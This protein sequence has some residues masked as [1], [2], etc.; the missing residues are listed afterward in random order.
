MPRALFWGTVTVM[1]LYVGIHWA[2]LTLVPTAELA[3]QIEIG[4][5]VAS[6]VFGTAGGKWMSAMLCVALVS[7]ASAMTWAGPRVTQVMG[8][9]FGF[10]R[11]LAHTN[12]AGIPMR[13]ILL[14][15]AIVFAMLLTSTFEWILVYVQLIL[16]LSSA[17]TVYGV[18][19]LRRREPDLERPYRTWG[20]P[21]TPLLF[22]GISALAMVH[23]F[24]RQP[25][26]SLAGLVTLL[27]ALPVYW[28]SPRLTD[29]SS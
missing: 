20:Y 21:V 3:G 24:A 10:F 27:V 7:S 6:Q 22:L 4:H 12:R 13:A 25:W 26:E 29:A 28:L 15:T 9:D 1:V 16:T 5:I 18:F 14:Q 11:A 17:L 8:Q 23:T 19:A 2:F